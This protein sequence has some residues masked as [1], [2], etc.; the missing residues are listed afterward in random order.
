MDEIA[1]KRA[2]VGPVS[3]RDFGILPKMEELDD[4]IQSKSE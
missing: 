3:R 1:G 2:I 4:G